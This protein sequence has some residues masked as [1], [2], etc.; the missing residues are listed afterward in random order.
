MNN[1]I[2]ICQTDVPSN[3]SQFSSSN[4]T[5]LGF[6]M[7][8]SSLMASQFGQTPTSGS[9]NQN[10]NMIGSNMFQLPAWAKDTNVTALPD[11]SSPAVS[12]RIPKQ[13]IVNCKIKYWI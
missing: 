10:F 4:T 1:A 6:E 11:T 12:G 3:E 2:F 5:L 13:Y 9:V 8:G 7:Q